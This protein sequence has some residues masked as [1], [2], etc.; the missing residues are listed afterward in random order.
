MYVIL[1][2]AYTGGKKKSYIDSIYNAISHFFSHWYHE[3]GE[4]FHF[5]EQRL[6]IILKSK[7]LLVR[8]N[9]SNLAFGGGIRK[10]GQVLMVLHL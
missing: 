8:L 2:C 4:A 10:D 6:G 3:K 7:R 5:V 1:W 9:Q